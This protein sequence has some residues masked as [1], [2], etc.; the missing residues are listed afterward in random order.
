MVQLIL[1]TPELLKDKL[2]SIK[3]LSLFE[4]KSI[5]SGCIHPSNRKEL[6]MTLSAPKGEADPEE[7]RS[8]SKTLVLCF[9]GPWHS[10]YAPFMD[11]NLVLHKG[12]A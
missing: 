8:T 10:L 11:Q 3:I 12:L 6:Q 5:R 1:L 4:Q 7:Y 2:K 9:S